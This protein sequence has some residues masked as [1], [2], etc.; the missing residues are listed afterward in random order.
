M[1]MYRDVERG[2]GIF[3]PVVHILTGGFQLPVLTVLSRIGQFS[4][5]TGPNPSPLP[6]MAVVAL[7]L[8]A[9]WTP[10]LRGN[11]Q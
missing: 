9:V 8:Y 6:I 10:R 1:A 4:E 7:M 5:Y 2:F 3:D 11:I